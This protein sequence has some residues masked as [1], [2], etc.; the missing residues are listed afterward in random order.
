MPTTDVG[1][2]TSHHVRIWHKAI[3]WWKPCTN[4]DS[5]MAGAKILHPIS[6]PL[7][8]VLQ[9]PSNKLTP[10]KGKDLGAAP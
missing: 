1:Y 4:Q 3:L 5:C 6:I 10:A 2:L 8:R 9:A 7:F